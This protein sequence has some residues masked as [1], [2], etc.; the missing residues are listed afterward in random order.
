M[1]FTENQAL[2]TPEPKSLTK[3]VPV[4]GIQPKM[5]RRT[6]KK[7]LSQTCIFMTD[8][9]ENINKIEQASPKITSSCLGKRP[10]AFWPL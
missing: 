9:R 5:F 3:I 2:S 10:H 4:S 1:S 6:K 8:L 7:S